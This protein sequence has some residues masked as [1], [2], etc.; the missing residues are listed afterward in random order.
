MLRAE[1]DQ[2]G[3]GSAGTAENFHG[4]SGTGSFLTARCPGHA[5]PDISRRNT[6]DTGNTGERYNRPVDPAVRNN[7]VAAASEY[8]IRYTG[9]AEPRDR[10]NERRHVCRL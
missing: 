8:E 1:I 2:G 9:L 10:K 6:A 7:D 4:L 3:D 5:L